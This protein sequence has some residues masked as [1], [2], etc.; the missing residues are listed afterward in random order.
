MEINIICN[1]IF[2][3]MFFLYTCAGRESDHIEI[4]TKSSYDNILDTTQKT[5]SVN[6]KNK[7]VNQ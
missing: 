1:A 7:Q 6:R 2:I 5:I 4:S 3:N